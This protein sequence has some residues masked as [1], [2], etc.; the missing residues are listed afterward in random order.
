[1]NINSTGSKHAA[2]AYPLVWPHGWPRT[3]TPQIN[4]KF[5]ARSVHAAHAELA[6][7]LGR[8][9]ATDMLISSNVTLGNDSPKD[10][11]ICV[12]FF[13]K[14]KNYALPCD[15]WTAVQDNLW[16]LAKHIEALRGQER[17]GV[18][19]LDRAFAGYLAIGN[20]EPNPEEWWTVLG[21]PRSATT[22]QLSDGYREAARKAH[23]DMNGGS[24]KQMVLI[25][26]AYAIARRT[27]KLT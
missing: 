19:T 12:Y 6:V 18:G 13:F 11:G 1:M 24:D 3:T 16:A 21:V 17:W 20:G 23:P 4:T 25:N 26:A 10:R 7:E 2:V 8:L 22:Q 27:L 9:G 14:G 15:R 5:A